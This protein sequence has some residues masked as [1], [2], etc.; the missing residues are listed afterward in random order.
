MS[1]KR[2]RSKRVTKSERVMLNLTD[3]APIQDIVVTLEVSAHGA[4]VLA[5]RH[6]QADARGTAMFIAAGRQVPCRIAWQRQPGPDGRMETGV[7]IYSNGNFWGLDLAGSEVE[8]EPSQPQL[9]PALKALSPAASTASHH[10]SHA[11][12]SSHTSH[13]TPAALK[14]TAA[15]PAPVT[16]PAAPPAPTAASTAAAVEQA[17]TVQAMLEALGG[18]KSASLP[19]DLWCT[20]VD[21]LEAKGVFSRAELIAMLKKI[22]QP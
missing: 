12:H 4:K 16:K 3:P 6:M 1:A 7:E 2:R 20:L 10:S 13:Q 8:P 17:T 21:N 9:P 5:R 18:S 14:P 11:G 19:I 15:A 22:G